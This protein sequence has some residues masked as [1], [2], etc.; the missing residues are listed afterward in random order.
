[1]NSKKVLYCGDCRMDDAAKY[2][3]GAMKYHRYPFDHIESDHR[4]NHRVSLSKYK[5]FILSDY[6]SKRWSQKQLLEICRQVELGASLWMIGGWGSFKGVDGNYHQ[7]PLADVLPVNISSKDDRRQG[8]IAY[9]L[10]S[11]GNV[12]RWF[13]LDF[14]TAPVIAGFNQVSLKKNAQ[15]LL[16]VETIHSKNG[17]KLEVLRTDPLLVAGKYGVGK[18]LAYMSDLAPHWSGGLVD[19]GS[20][21]IQIPIQHK[22][23]IQVSNT[24]LNFIGAMLNLLDATTQTDLKGLG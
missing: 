13:G 5:L 24:Y 19:W 14:K 15:P 4:I 8:A 23:S 20:K 22:I 16:N 17:K 2:L 7:T 21:R 6:P 3:A 1:M 12:D 10:A 18:V 11:L 9:R